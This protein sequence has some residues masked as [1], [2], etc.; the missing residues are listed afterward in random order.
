[1]GLFA[2]PVNAHRQ[3]AAFLQR[4]FAPLPKPGFL[5]LREGEHGLPGLVFYMLVVSAQQFP[6]DPTEKDNAIIL[7]DNHDAQ[8]ELVQNRQQMLAPF[9]QF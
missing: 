2:G 6:P 3:P 7:I 4:T 9:V 8:M 5:L 1:M